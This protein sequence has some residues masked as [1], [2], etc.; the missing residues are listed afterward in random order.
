[1][2]NTLFK[3]L[4]NAELIKA[5]GRDLLGSIFENIGLLVRYYGRAKCMLG[6][7]RCSTEVQFSDVSTFSGERETD[8]VAATVR[9]SV[10]AGDD[11]FA[12][13]GRRGG[14]RAKGR[15]GR[16]HHRVDDVRV[17]LSCKCCT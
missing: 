11:F 13:C 5:S 12:I 8:S 4:E 14:Y 17:F 6:W 2:G 7:I 15:V 1:M 10:T 9:V 16:A 3:L